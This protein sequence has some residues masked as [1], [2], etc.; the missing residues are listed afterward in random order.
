MGVE[1]SVKQHLE[2]PDAAF[3]AKAMAKVA[4]PKPAPKAKPKP[5]PPGLQAG[6]S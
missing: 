3:K 5:A 1:A 4:A 6:Y 2:A